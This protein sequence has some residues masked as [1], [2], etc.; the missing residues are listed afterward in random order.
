MRMKAAYLLISL[1][2]WGQFDD[3]LLAPAPIVRSAPCLG[4]DDE[5]VTVE[6]ER[7]CQ[8]SPGAQR[9][10]RSKVDTE[11]VISIRPKS[12][13]PGRLSGAG[14]FCCPL[15]FTLMSLQL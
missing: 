13:E 2:L 12:H 10:V 4:D 3:V 9:P 6:R 14:T 11:K 15:L 8:R 7:G 5:Y 1:T